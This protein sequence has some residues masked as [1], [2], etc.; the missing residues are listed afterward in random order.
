MTD[1]GQPM[2]LQIADSLR[3]Q[4]AD[5]R[6]APGAE[7]PREADIVRQWG[8][9]RQTARAAL[10]ELERTGTV[11]GRPLRVTRH[12][13][14]VVHIAR[15]D[16]LTWAEE[17]PTLGADAWVGDVQRAGHSPVQKIRV[18]PVVPSEDVIRRL[19]LP[20]GITVTER[21][22]LRQAGSEPDNL[23]T[24]WFPRDLA[25]GTLLAEPDS[26]KE[27]SVAWLE[28]TYGKLQHGISVAARMPGPHEKFQLQIPP[29]W[30]VLV[31]WRVSRTEKRPVV[32]SMAVYPAD[33]AVLVLD[34]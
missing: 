19:R 2:Y 18:G 6:L 8:V 4:I 3:D 7:V 16:D 24:F 21:R 32:T 15:T 11:S 30:P 9:A 20:V 27:G 13:P 1:T 5:G 26:I 34:L 31:V 28:K 17:L 23:I 33:R 10:D 12:Q 25:D 29:G 22:L 14:R